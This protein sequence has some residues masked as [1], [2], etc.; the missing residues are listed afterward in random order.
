MPHNPQQ[1]S[2]LTPSALTGNEHVTLEGE[3]NPLL[4]QAVYGES[5]TLH[6]RQVGLLALLDM[7]ST[8][9]KRSGLERGQHSD[10]HA[11]QIYE[12]HTPEALE[13]YDQNRT[14][15][16]KV[17]KGEPLQDKLIREKF[18]SSTGY[19][20]RNPKDKTPWVQTEAQSIGSTAFKA[21]KRQYSGGGSKGEKARAALRN[22][23]DPTKE[24]RK[25]IRT[26]KRERK[27]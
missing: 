16:Q 17:V 19:E 12:T 25:V 6:E 18:A 26:P 14:R 4:N 20:V 3:P 5:I 24:I 11:E 15:L 1:E 21:F 9:G 7:V 22:T 23:L 10:Q 8:A 27:S 2:F 13:R